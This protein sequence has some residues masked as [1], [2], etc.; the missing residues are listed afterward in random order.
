MPCEF[1]NEPNA[2]GDY[3]PCCY[4][5]D[6][7]CMAHYTEESISMCIC[8]GAEMIKD[9]SGSW[10]HYSQMDLPLSKRY[11]VHHMEQKPE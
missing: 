5:G 3:D 10:R 4:H 6:G 9:E 2:F 11:L 8:C 1:C 7:T